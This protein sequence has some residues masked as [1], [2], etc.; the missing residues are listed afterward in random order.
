MTQGYYAPTMMSPM[1]SM[2][3]G[4][5]V[6]GG[7]VGAGGYPSAGYGASPMTGMYGGASGGGG[8]MYSVTST[9]GGSSVL[10]PTKA[11]SGSSPMMIAPPAR[12][13]SGKPDPFAN[14]MK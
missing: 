10:T 3:V 9:Y 1:T 13:N 8:A 2:H 11:P 7:G 5:G 14:L 6:G 4:V 12:P